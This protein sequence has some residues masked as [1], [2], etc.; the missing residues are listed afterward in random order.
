MEIIDISF[1]DIFVDEKINNNN[2]VSYKTT[3]MGSISLHT[4]FD[5]INEFVKT[6]DGI[7]YLVLFSYLY[8][9][10]YKEIKYLI[11]EKGGFT[12]SIYYNFAKIRIDLFKFLLIEKMLT[13]HNVIILVKLVANENKNKYY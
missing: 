13:V 8:D 3:F 1:R 7:R 5:K 12:D 10:I 11:S 4:R 2:G 6:D 9:E